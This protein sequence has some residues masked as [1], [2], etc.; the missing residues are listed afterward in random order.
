VSVTAP[1]KEEAG[2]L[3][4]TAVEG[5]LAACA[6]VSG[7][8]SS[9]YW[10][11]GEVITAPEYLLTLKTTSD[12]LPVLVEAIRKAHSF[13]VPEIVVLPIVA[14]DSAYLAWIADETRER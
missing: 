5:R 14:G 12:R 13:E 11:E 6:Q 2:Y 4:R 7:P 3:G 10:W 8:L 9:T 1:S